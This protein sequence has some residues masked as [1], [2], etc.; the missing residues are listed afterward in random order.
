MKTRLL[1][2]IL[3]LLILTVLL[4]RNTNAF[5]PLV[6]GI[7]NP[8][9]QTYNNFT[10]NIEDK[11]KSY[12]FQ[13]ETIEKLSKE[14]SA[15][16]KLLLEQAHYIKQVKN[17]YEVLPDIPKQPVKNIAIVDTI[18]YVKLNSFSQIILTTPKS[19][20]EKKIYGLISGNSVG[21]TATLKNNQLYGRL[22]SDEK[23]RFSVLI[24]KNYAPGIAEGHQNNLMV[25]KFIPSWYSIN[26]HDKV[27]T[28]G[29]DNIFFAGLAV[30]I[31]K[32]VET[33][34]AYK[35]AYV[36]TYNN[37]YNPKSFLLITDAEAT[38]A[39]HI[40][41]NPIRISA[42]PPIQSNASKQ[43]SPQT[44]PATTQTIQETFAD[45]HVEVPQEASS[46]TKPPH[47]KVEGT[48]E[49]PS[50]IEQTRIGDVEPQEMIEE[51]VSKPKLNP[52]HQESGLDLF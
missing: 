51:R 6:L 18:S 28:S 9:K 44:T 22:T 2:V 3:L 27:I 47:K 39:K 43:N 49:K 33:K 4:T 36:Q 26:K 16:K 30:G 1:A 23:C 37:V 48:S 10:Q 19:L 40:R 25:V 8:V 17:I 15:L 20:D 14:N 5:V 13:K 32:K 11:S 34:G 21:G 35:I 46:T 12:I 7:L 41:H 29:L 31:V 38:L 42:R 52:Q 24:G 45:I 50:A